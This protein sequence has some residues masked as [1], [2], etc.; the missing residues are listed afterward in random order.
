MKACARVSTLGL[1]V[2]ASALWY[3]ACSGGSPSPPPPDPS[4]AAPAS[5]TSGG[6]DTGPGSS[7]PGPAGEPQT[8]ADCE[9]L[10]TEITNDPPDGGVAMNNAMTAGDAGASDRLLPIIEVMKGHRDR[11]R[12]C[13]DLWGRKNPGQEGKVTFVIEL[14]PSGELVS[15][16]INHDESDLH[17]QE[18]ESCMAKVAGGLPF[19]AS[20]TGKDTTYTH[21]F[22]FKAKAH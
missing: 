3:S 8:A 9:T 11:F 4:T 18:V 15:A 10:V 6:D 16:K 22:N 12:C 2:T 20:P 13:F 19:P 5:P 14:K 17:A 1:F 7:P 21:R